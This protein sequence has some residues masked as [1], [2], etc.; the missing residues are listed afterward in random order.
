MHFIVSGGRAEERIALLYAHLFVMIIKKKRFVNRH[1]SL[2]Q[3]GDHF[4]V[5][6]YL[7]IRREQ[8]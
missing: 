4:P 1:L 5:P 2:F 3:R 6:G 8:N 7:A